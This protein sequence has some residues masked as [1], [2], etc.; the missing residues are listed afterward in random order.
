MQLIH[1]SFI[2]SANQTPKYVLQEDKPINEQPECLAYNIDFEL[3]QKLIPCKDAPV[4]G[5]GQFGRVVSI[6]IEIPFQY[7]QYPAAVK[8]ILSNY[9]TAD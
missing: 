1:N 3:P 9:R 4:L 8:C 7:E 5:S 6:N 2:A